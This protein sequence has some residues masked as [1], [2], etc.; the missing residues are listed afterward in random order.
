MAQR[1]LKDQLFRRDV[2]ASVA[3]D[4]IMGVLRAPFMVASYYRSDLLFAH[5]EIC[6]HYAHRENERF[7]LYFNNARISPFKDRAEL[8]AHFCGGTPLLDRQHAATQQL[9]AAE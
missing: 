4:Y 8:I 7:E 5:C 3:A 6:Y 9:Q 2:D 1:T